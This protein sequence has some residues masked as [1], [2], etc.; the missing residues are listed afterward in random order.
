MYT[1]LPFVSY[2]LASSHLLAAGSPAAPGNPAA[3]G[4]ASL[5][6]AARATGS[7]GKGL[8]GPSAPPPAAATPVPLSRA[9]GSTSAAALPAPSSLPQQTADGGRAAPP[10]A[11]RKAAGKAAVTSVWRPAPGSADA[12]ARPL[13]A[14]PSTWR[15][16]LEFY[17]PQLARLLTGLSFAGLIKLLCMAGNVLV[18]VSPYPQVQRWE[19][20]GCTGDADAAPYVSIAFGGWQWCFYGAFAYL[21]TRRSGF[22]ILVH[23]NCLGAV[24]GTYYTAAFH[25]NCR[26]QRSLNSLNWYLSAVSALALL[27]MCSLLMLPAE[28]ALFLSGL[29]SSFC[30][31]VGAISML[32][33]VPAVIKNRDSRSIPGPMVLANFMS[34]LVWCL[35]GWML[36]DPLVIGPN[37]VAAI[38]SLVCMYMKVHFPSDRKQADQEEP[39]EA[40]A[41]IS[42]FAGPSKK[43]MT[44]TANEFTPLGAAAS[45]ASAASTSE[46]STADP[47]PKYATAAQFSDG[48]GGT[49]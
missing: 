42:S 23:S 1:I 28:R 38:A 14:P 43:Q 7:L 37:I 46:G 27:Q 10:D 3:P 13:A 12:A 25:K 31:F 49:F 34:A 45:S 26:H 19:R 48:T 9:G 16:W 8:P 11:G 35:C 20:R 47:A 40:A 22:L 18:Q 44:V 33:T 6:G 15:I 41:I 39:D 30:S 2:L 36:A 32:V 24:L 17:S 29:I 4:A 5:L 21:V